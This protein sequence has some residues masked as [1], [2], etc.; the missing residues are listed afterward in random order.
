VCSAASPVASPRALSC[1]RSPVASPR[2]LSCNRSPVASP[3]ALSCN[4]SNDTS[5]DGRWHQKHCSNN[6]FVLANTIQQA[7]PFDP[8]SQKTVQKEEHVASAY[9]R[10]RGFGEV[11]I[12][13]TG[14][15]RLNCRM[16]ARLLVDVD[17]NDRSEG[18]FYFCRKCHENG[19]RYHICTTCWQDLNLAVEDVDPFDVHSILSADPGSSAGSEAAL[20]VSPATVL[21]GL[22]KGS[23]TEGTYK[24]DAALTLTFNKQ[25]EIT[26]S[27]PTKEEEVTVSGLWRRDGLTIMVAWSESRAWG[28]TRVD[29]QFTVSEDTAKITAKMIA[30]DGGEASLVLSRRL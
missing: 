7:Y 16:C 17:D 9:D 1:N 15:R 18:P 26:G 19:R 27:G 14:P 25:G 4:R 20:G 22:W 8:Y 28:K 6:L 21:P 23:I 24:R 12:T 2:A 5:K 11:T 30:S 10:R 3:R 29:G 13:K